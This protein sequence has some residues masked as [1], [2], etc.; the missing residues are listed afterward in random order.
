[1]ARTP[2]TLASTSRG[3]YSGRLPPGDFATLIARMYPQQ[4]QVSL[5][6]A[7]RSRRPRHSR[8]RGCSFCSALGGSG[9][10]KIG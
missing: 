8:V 4:P 6:R 5:I 9:D 1:M 3:T 10:T 2:C 7:D